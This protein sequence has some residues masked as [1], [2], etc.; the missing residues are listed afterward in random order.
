MLGL[1]ITGGEGPK[2]DV[3]RSL[4]REAGIVIAADSGLIAAENAGITVDLI[5]GD[6]DSLDSRKRLEKYPAHKIQSFSHDKDFTDTE[7]A[8]DVL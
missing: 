1:V 7:L 2:P 6:M 5:I 8:L 4:A 3:C